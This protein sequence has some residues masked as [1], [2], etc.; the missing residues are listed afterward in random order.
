MSY[1]VDH[2]AMAAKHLARITGVLYLI[3]AIFGMFAGTVSTNLMVAG[4]PAASAGNVMA[5]LALVRA[6]LAAWVIVLFADIAMTITLFVLL[7]PAAAGELALTLW[8][9]VRGVRIRRTGGLQQPD[10]SQPQGQRVIAA[11]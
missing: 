11:A 5:S 8:L 1:D 4:D 10:Q 7:T 6:S 9:I 3:I 2:H